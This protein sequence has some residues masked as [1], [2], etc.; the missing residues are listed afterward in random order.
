MDLKT[1]INNIDNRPANRTVDL[2]STKADK[3][4]ATW[5]GSNKFVSTEDPTEIDGKDGDIWF[6]IES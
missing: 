2:L 1:L 3:E 5:E 6:K 4:T